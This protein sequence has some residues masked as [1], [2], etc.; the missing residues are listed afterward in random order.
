MKN[1]NNTYYDPTEVYSDSKELEHDTSSDKLDLDKKDFTKGNKL[2]DNPT[3][4]H[5][6]YT[7]KDNNFDS[8]C[9]SYIVSKQTQVV[10]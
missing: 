4:I 7:I 8:L 9:S 10:I 5:S 1:L 3:R 2:T 6:V